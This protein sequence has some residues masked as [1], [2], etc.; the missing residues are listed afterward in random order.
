MVRALQ[1]L[2]N[3]TTVLNFEQPLALVIVK[4]TLE[5]D[6]AGK[7]IDLGF[8]LGFSILSVNLVVGHI[9]AD[10]IQRLAF[11]ARVHADRL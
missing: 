6:R 3:R 7:F 9:D 1:R 11:A 10:V 8:G 4:I 2:V 5:C